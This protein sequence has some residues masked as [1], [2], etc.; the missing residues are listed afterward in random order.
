MLGLINFNQI[1][2]CVFSIGVVYFDSI[3]TLCRSKHQSNSSACF[4]SEL[5][6]L[7]CYYVFGGAFL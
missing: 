6:K 3:H 1:T 2:F 5:T 7:H 4:D